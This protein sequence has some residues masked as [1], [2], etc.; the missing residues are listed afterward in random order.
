MPNFA[1]VIFDAF[2]HRGDAILRIGGDDG[3]ISVKISI[4]AISLC[5]HLICCHLISE[6]SDFSV[7]L[8]PDERPLFHML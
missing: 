4:V 8:N 1:G 7:V 5:C 3:E 2:W 6:I